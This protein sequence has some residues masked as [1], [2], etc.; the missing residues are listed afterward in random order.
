MALL[1]IERIQNQWD[2]VQEH[3]QNRRQ[4]LNE[5]LKDS[6]Q[7]L[8]AKEEAEQVLGQ[9]RA[10]LESWKEG[11][12][13]IDAIQKKITET[14]LLC[15]R[16]SELLRGQGF[17]FYDENT[18]KIGPNLAMDS[19]EKLFLDRFK[20]SFPVSREI[21]TGSDYRNEKIAA[22]VE[23]NYY[24]DGSL[25]HRM[26][27]ELFSFMFIR[28]KH[29]FYFDT[30]I[31]FMQ[32]AK[33]LHQW[34]INVDVANDL[35]LKLLRDYSADDTRKVHMITEN[36]NA[37]WGSIQKR[38]DSVESILIT[39]LHT[40]QLC[41]LASANVKTTQCQLPSYTL[42]IT[43]TILSVTSPTLPPPYV[44]GS[45]MENNFL[46]YMVAAGRKVN[47]APVLN[48]A[49][50]LTPFYLHISLNGISR[51]MLAF[52][53]RELLG[54]VSFH[55][56]TETQSSTAKY[57]VLPSNFMANIKFD[58]ITT[59]LP[60]L[61]L[62][63]KSKHENY[64]L[65]K[66]RREAALEETHRLLQQ[67]PLDLEEFLAWLTEAE[68]TANVLQDATHKER[69]LEDSNRVKELMKQWQLIYFAALVYRVSDSGNL[70]LLNLS[71]LLYHP[72]LTPLSPPKCMLS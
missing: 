61:T 18:F 56:L 8:E 67:F 17:S 5:M 28:N 2:E 11:P 47:D 29:L 22:S 32:L 23:H 26:A 46:R 48:F 34:Q 54:P 36:I 39:S 42:L 3:L 60:F 12:Y 69:L 50:L 44:T 35:A 66:Q 57:N 51:L 21:F 58:I 10:K 9:A 64:F 33:D 4:Q 20:L 15:Q 68:T 41:L 53:S 38:R 70:W 25:H 40:V 45:K 7:W 72:P 49:S 71:F 37:S 24:L 1:S 63:M 30:G 62:W 31:S 55:T 13:T 27:K 52:A 16:D 65:W 14:K 19:L 59:N 6:T 43:R